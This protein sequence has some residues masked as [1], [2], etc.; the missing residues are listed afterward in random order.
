MIIIILIL[1]FCT[2][3][4]LYTSNIYSNCGKQELQEIKI[5]PV[6]NDIVGIKEKNNLFTDVYNEENQ[7]II[8][9]NE[10]VLKAF[11]S[12]SLPHPLFS[13]PP[14]LNSILPSLYLVLKL[15][16]T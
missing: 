5:F 9:F 10:Q 15:R 3:T 13:S 6:T 11:P 8:K 1:K 14:L 16:C 2:V 7:K 12:A 4:S